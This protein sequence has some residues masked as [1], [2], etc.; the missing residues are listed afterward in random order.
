MTKFKTALLATMMAASPLFASPAFAG[1]EMWNGSAWVST[2]TAT[3]TGATTATVSGIAVPCSSATFNLTLTSGVAT[4]SG[5]TFTGG[6]ACTNNVT[7]LNLPWSISAGTPGATSSAITIGG[8]VGSPGQVQVKFNTPS[9]TCTGGVAAGTLANLGN[10]ATNS[11]FTFT[12]DFLPKPS[13][14]TNVRSTSTL[15]A[16]RPLRFT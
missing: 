12:A 11:T 4:V 2:G 3:I 9:Q 7:A 5:A 15:T 13:P 16:S 14:C 6:S 10:S 8:T 1:W